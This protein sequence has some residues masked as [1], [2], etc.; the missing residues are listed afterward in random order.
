MRAIFCSK[1]G[2]LPNSGFTP[3]QQ[4][5]LVVSKKRPSEMI[6]RPKSREETPKEGSDNFQEAIALQ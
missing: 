5:A 1:R 4:C 2:G 6:E 3:I